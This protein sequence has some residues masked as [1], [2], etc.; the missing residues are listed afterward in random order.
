MRAAW[1]HGLF[2]FLSMV[3]LLWALGLAGLSL[4]LCPHRQ[5][6]G[7]V[8]GSQGGLAGTVLSRRSTLWLG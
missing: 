3:V 1:S 2:P 6:L 4:S 7:P 5:S 8:M